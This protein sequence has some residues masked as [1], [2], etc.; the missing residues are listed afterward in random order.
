[1][2]GKNLVIADTLSRAPA[3]AGSKDEGV[4]SEEVEAYVEA[5]LEY[6]PATERR[7]EKICKHQ[8]EDEVLQRTVK[9][10]LSGW[11]E[12]YNMPES[13]KPLYSVAVELTVQKRLPMRDS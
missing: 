12:Q 13:V 5:V 3:P 10:C 6:L 1:M 9:Y 2:P 7:L 8:K 11:P 4:L